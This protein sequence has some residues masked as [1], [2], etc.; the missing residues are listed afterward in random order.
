MSKGGARAPPA[1]DPIALALGQQQANTNTA[2]QQSVL[3][4]SNTTSPFGTANWSQGP[5]GQWQLNQSLGSN[6]SPV[7]GSQTSLAA[8]LAGLGGNVANLASSPA[9]A[10]AGIVNTA[11]NNLIGQIP[12]GPVSTEGLPGAISNVAGGP[13]QTSLAPGGPIQG[14]VDTNFGNQVRQAQNAA[15]NTQAGYLD[16]QFQEKHSD[17]TQQL[18][19][20]GLSAGSE[21]YDRAQGDLGRQ[22]T[23]AYQQAKDAAV[24]AG[25]QE[26]STLFGESLGAG[27][28]A[29]AAQQQGFGQNTV[30][31]EFANQAQQQGFGQGVTNAQ[32]SDQARQQLFNERTTQW[33]EPL[34]ALAS[35]ANSGEGILSGISGQLG[36]LGSLG[37]FAWGGSIPTYGGNPTTVNPTNFI[38]AQQTANTSALNRF[39]A[40][41]TLNNQ[42]FNGIGSLG[43]ALGLASGGLGSWLGSLFGGGSGGGTYPGDWGA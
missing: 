7:F 21:A 2:Q 24:A 30:A 23:L 40:G 42:L 35:A 29:N 8:Q 33:G 9:Q 13:I 16:P 1:V 17:L 37:N 11:Y 28:F 43:G 18:A 27:Q 39:A 22:E 19:D 26:Q 5:D 10:G 25:N 3:N 6:T 15:Y 12:T 36:G 38:G 34:Q 32:L 20:Q 31:G 4:N 41:N 14:S